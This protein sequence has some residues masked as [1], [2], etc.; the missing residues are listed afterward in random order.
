MMPPVIRQNLAQLEKL[1]ALLKQIDQRL[2]SEEIPVLGNASLGMHV[3][4]IL[5]FYICL[6]QGLESGEVNYDG[7]KRDAALESDPVTAVDAIERIAG[8]LRNCEEDRPLQ[9]YSSVEIA[10]EYETIRF[11]S[12]LYRE[13]HYNQEHAIHHMA[14]I[15]MALR[16]CGKESLADHDFG[17]AP[18]TLKSGRSCAQ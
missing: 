11:Q 14:M 13:L 8:F 7:R 4:H 12:S 10:P 3:R 5:E 17:I 15:R 1:E 6:K 9:L 2:Y 18:S 16:L